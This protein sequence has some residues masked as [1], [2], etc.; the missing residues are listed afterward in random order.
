LQGRV[1]AE[2]KN[3]PA[4]DEWLKKASKDAKL[5]MSVCTG[6]Y[7]L[8][9]DGLLDGKDATTHHAFQNDFEQTFPNIHMKRGV[10]FVENGDIATAG[11]LTSGID[12]ALRIETNMRLTAVR[13]V[14]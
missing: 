10:R 2:N 6:A 4:R 7:I 3:S 8:A 12:L 13:S 9:K 14:T 1:P 11:G 5:T